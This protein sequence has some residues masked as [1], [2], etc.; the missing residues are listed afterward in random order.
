MTVQYLEP[1]LLVVWRDRS[2]AVPLLPSG[3]GVGGTPY[4]VLFREAPLE[5]GCFF[6]LAVHER[7]GTIVILVFERFRRNTLSSKRDI[8]L[9]N[10]TII[11]D[12]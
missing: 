5:R 3:W 1:W 7:A 11:K 9:L 8:Y 10:G 4:S 6:M 12:L 2:C